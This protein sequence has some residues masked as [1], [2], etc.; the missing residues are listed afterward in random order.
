[1]R[2]PLIFFRVRV[3]PFQKRDVIGLTDVIAFEMRRVVIEC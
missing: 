3:P 1:M 2:R